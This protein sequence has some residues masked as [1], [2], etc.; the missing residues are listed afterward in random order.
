MKYFLIV[1]LLATS[2]LSGC[3]EKEKSNYKTITFWHFWSEPYQRV[4]IDSLIQAF[5]KQEGIKVEVTEL[6]W[7]DGKVKLL[8]A[9]NSNTAPDVLELGS[10]WVAQFSSAG[11]LAKISKKDAQMDRFLK[12][13][14]EPCFW[15]GGIYALPWIVDTRVLF[16]NMDLLK[17]NGFNEPPKT[18]DEMLNMSKVIN[19]NGTFG[20]GVNGSDKHRLY[21]KVLT[22]IWSEGG[23]IYDGHKFTFDTPEV[24]SGVA[25]YKEMEKY[26]IVDTQK[27]LD[28][29][30]ANGQLAFWISGSWLLK[31]ITEF[32]KVDDLRLVEIPDFSQKGISFA[33]GEYFSI[34]NKSEKQDMALKFVKFMT[35]GKNA[36]EFCKR[37]PEGGFPADKQYY[38]SDFYDSKYKAVVAKQLEHS[39]MTPVHPK[40]LEV[41]ELFEGYVEQVLYNKMTPEQAMKELES[42]VK[43][44]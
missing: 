4:V 23:T 9:F 24:I 10:D 13:A 28:N 34:N 32:G 39:K 11:V 35:D 20:F 7:N 21:K 37:I 12:F 40:W 3:G 5:E 19:N 18:Y 36:V 41:E 27:E 33:G 22:F 8:A 16:V 43:D 17:K 30:F 44:F 29:Y 26:G 1:I 25:K 38:S 2:L 14:Q 6:S 15:D 42:K 31:K